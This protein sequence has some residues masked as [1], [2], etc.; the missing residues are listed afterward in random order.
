[1]DIEPRIH[2]HKVCS[3]EILCV[4]LKFEGFFL[5]IFKLYSEKLVQCI[6]F[7][8]LLISFYYL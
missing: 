4:Q 1:M 7:K 2:P 6:L 8:V 5:V 3:L